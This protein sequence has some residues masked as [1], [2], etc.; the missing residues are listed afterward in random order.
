MAPVQNA[1][2]VAVPAATSAADLAAALR[3][4]SPEQIVD[5]LLAGLREQMR[6]KKLADIYK[7]THDQLQAFLRPFFKS[8]QDVQEILSDV[9]IALLEGK[10]GE[11]HLR[12]AAKLK[13]IN[14]QKRLAVETNLFVPH[15]AR[16]LGQCS[17]SDSE[18][19]EDMAVAFDFAS[20]HAEDRDP[21]DILISREEAV[22]HD[23]QLQA[24]K[25]IAKT[26]WRY[27]WLNQKQWARPLLAPEAQ[28]S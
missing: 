11:G 24:A 14:R 16:Q 2:L 18:G 27:R 25:H 3:A 10:S 8:E 20:N 9:Y 15:D 12:R 5:D 1:V 22:E 28:A 19:G 26:D 6:H 21:L 4:S 23:R 7:E 17:Q 13:A